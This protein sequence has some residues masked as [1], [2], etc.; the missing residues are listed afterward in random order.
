MVDFKNSKFLAEVMQQTRNQEAVLP[1]RAD[2]DPTYP[3]FNFEEGHMYL[4]YV[5]HVETPDGTGTYRTVEVEKDGKTIKREVFNADTPLVHGVKTTYNKNGVE[6]YMMRNVR[7]INGLNLPELG[8]SP[9]N[10]CPLCNAAVESQ[11]LLREQVTSAHPGENLQGMDWFTAAQKFDSTRQVTGIN[12]KDQDKSRRY[13]F[14]AGIVEVKLDGMNYQIVSEEPIMVFM[15]LSHN[16]WAKWQDACAGVAE[17]PAGQWFRLSYPNSNGSKM[18]SGRNMTVAILNIPGNEFGDKLKELSAAFDSEFLHGK[19]P[20]N[21]HPWTLDVIYE[22]V[23]SS[24][25]LPYDE[26][27]K[28][29]D[30]ALQQNE[31]TRLSLHGGTQEPSE[32]GITASAGV[33]GGGITGNAGTAVPPQLSASDVLG[34]VDVLP[35]TSAQATKAA[36]AAAPTPQATVGDVD[37]LT[38]D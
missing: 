20:E 21:P 37:D 24:R 5:P 36:Q 7:C 28:I 34:Q 10:G 14:A 13:V 17:T 29:E 18:E 27:K 16:Q 35:S 6:R 11:K 12:S 1:G 9:K 2:Y 32:A 25:F 33:A 15:D 30:N 38:L 22:K 3:R 4:A 8:Y 23:S 31:L 19:D 26:L